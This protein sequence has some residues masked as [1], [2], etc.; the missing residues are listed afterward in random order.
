MS[1]TTWVDERL[2][3]I[4]DEVVAAVSAQITTDL[5]TLENNVS[6]LLSQQEAEI[7]SNI[8]TGV[9]QVVTNAATNS[10][11]VIETVGGTFTNALDHFTIDTVSL[12]QAVAQA[13]K[14]LLPF[15]FGSKGKQ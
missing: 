12:A 3:K 10:E 1:I 8:T 15:P 6:L 9:D 7:I 11:K 13:I 2:K 4:T 5:G 14:G